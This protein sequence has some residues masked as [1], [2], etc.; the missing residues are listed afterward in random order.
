M[1][2][3]TCSHVVRAGLLLMALGCAPS[4]KVSRFRSN[5]ALY[6]A[7][8]QQLQRKKWDN[9]IAVFEKLTLELPPRDTLLPKAYLYL[10][11]A[12]SGKKEHLLAAQAYSRLAETFPDDTLADDAMLAEG[13]EYGKM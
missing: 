13:R 1:F 7:G 6:R 4:F 12:H 5:D 11:R 2:R 10:A 3:P 8:L 9:S